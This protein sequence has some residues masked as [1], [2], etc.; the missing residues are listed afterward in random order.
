MYDMLNESYRFLQDI[1][2]DQSDDATVEN[3]LNI[4]NEILWSGGAGGLA[5]LFPY[6]KPFI[7]KNFLGIDKVKQKD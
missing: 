6:I 5:K 4:R 2:P 1:P 3:I 7:G